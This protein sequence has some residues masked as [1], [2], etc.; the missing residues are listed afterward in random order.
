MSL[1]VAF[2]EEMM[3]AQDVVIN[4]AGWYLNILVI[5]RYWNQMIHISFKLVL[6]WFRNSF[7]ARRLVI[8]MLLKTKTWYLQNQIDEK[9]KHPNRTH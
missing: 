2:Y 6:L 5:P 7:K 9:S 8:A 1:C 4:R 3:F